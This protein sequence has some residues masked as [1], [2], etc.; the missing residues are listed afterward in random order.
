MISR[1]LTAVVHQL[2]HP[3]KEKKKKEFDFDKI[4]KKRKRKT[5]K[6]YLCST[7]LIYLVITLSI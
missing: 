5:K 4:N 1:Y 2:S 6:I 7:E 3:L